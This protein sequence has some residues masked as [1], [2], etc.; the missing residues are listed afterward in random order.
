MHLQLSTY[1]VNQQDLLNQISAYKLELAEVSKLLNDSN[2][3]LKVSELESSRM[4]YLSQIEL[5]KQNE[6]LVVS[7]LQCLRDQNENMQV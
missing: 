4:E 2:S 7:D 3:E 5:L 6:A 1:E